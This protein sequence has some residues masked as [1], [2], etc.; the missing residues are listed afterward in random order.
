M[1]F[2]D[3]LE[4]ADDKIRALTAYKPGFDDSLKPFVKIKSAECLGK[5]ASGLRCVR[6]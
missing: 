5:H 4:V 6:A 1:S 3:P 2:G